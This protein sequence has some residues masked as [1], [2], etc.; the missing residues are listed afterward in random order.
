METI[1]LCSE[2]Q[3][4]ILGIWAS[5]WKTQIAVV[6]VVVVQLLSCLW[7]FATLWAAT[8]QASLSFTTSQ[9]L[10]KLLSTESMLTSNYLIPWGPFSCPQSFPASG[11]FPMSQFFTSG[12]ES[13]GASASASVFPMNIQCWL[14]LGL[15]GLISFQSKSLLQH[16]NSEAS[17][18]QHSAFFMVQMFSKLKTFSSAIQFETSL[19]SLSLEE[20]AAWA[21]FLIWWRLLDGLIT[22]Y[23]NAQINI[24]K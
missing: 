1:V 4:G 12:G 19:M 16:H 18:L 14:H 17:I 21:L 20:W 9:S 3:I 2:T 8:P 23:K 10:L 11:S 6:A 7:L 24:W 22:M 5:A 13:I 15:T